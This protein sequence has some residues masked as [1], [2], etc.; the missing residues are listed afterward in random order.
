MQ[1]LT[2]EYIDV[3]KRR[4]M[5]QGVMDSDALNEM[6]D[7]ITIII[8]KF[9]SK[10][11]SFQIALE[12]ALQEFNNRDLI[13]IEANKKSLYL[14][15]KFLNKNF[16]F[17]LFFL[18]ATVYSLGIYLRM[19]D[20]Q[21]KKIFLVTGAITFGY[22]F[23][24]SLLLFWLNEYANKTKRIIAFMLLFSL[25]HYSIGLVLQWP[26]AKWLLLISGIFG[27]AYFVMF[28][29]IPAINKYLKK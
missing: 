5:Q 13:D 6:T 10:G 27:I 3:I 1:Q 25:F 21:G 7:H 28:I 19:N 16:L 15:P 14:F 26:I 23:L 18:S 8:E 22:I 20:L 9:M 24:P 12:N 11:E 17:V 29:V 4:L 2:D